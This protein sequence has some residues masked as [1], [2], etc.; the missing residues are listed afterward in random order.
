[1]TT[2]VEG[3]GARPVRLS[4]VMHMFNVQSYVAQA[5]RS[6]LASSLSDL[7]LILVDDGSTDDTQRVATEAAAGDPRVH[8]VSQANGGAGAARNTGLARAV[9]E[10]LTFA[11]ADDLVEP[12][13]YERAVGLLDRT[14]SDFCVAGHRRL[15]RSGEVLPGFGR[16]LFATQRLRITID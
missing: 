10:Y 9:G 11:D 5:V 13:H 1:M 2:P 3:S 7:E 12:D 6:V 14:G 4:V 15:T 8:L 16:Q